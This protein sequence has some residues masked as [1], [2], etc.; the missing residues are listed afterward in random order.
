[1][2]TSRASHTRPRAAFCFVVAV[3]PP[4]FGLGAKRPTACNALL[5]LAAATGHPLALGGEWN[6][7][8]ENPVWVL[9]PLGF[10]S[11]YVVPGLGFCLCR[12]EHR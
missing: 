10:R 4:C 9:W 3:C 6:K 5:L 11:T 8:T 12:I 2:M 1:M 7:W